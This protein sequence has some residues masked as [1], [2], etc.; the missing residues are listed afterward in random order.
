MKIPVVDDMSSM[1]GVICHILH[2]LGYRDVEQAGD[3]I[4]ALKRLRNATFDF[5][6]S[7]WNMPNMNGQELLAYIRG[8]DKLKTLPV[9]MVTAETEKKVVLSAVNSGVN[10]FIVKSFSPDQLQ[11]KIAIIFKK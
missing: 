5:V 7:D 1:R 8:D 11:E 6:I 4:Q 3:G 10:A 2:E 9:L